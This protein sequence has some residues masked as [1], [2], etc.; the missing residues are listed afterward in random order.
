MTHQTTLQRADFFERPRTAF[1]LIEL[2]VVISIIALLIALLLPALKAARETAR[3]VSC[4]SNLRQGA[5]AVVVYATETNGYLPPGAARVG[6]LDNVYANIGDHMGMVNSSGTPLS[7]GRRLGGDAS[8]LICPSW[9]NHLNGTANQ[10]R[11]KT[12]LFAMDINRASP[13]KDNQTPATINTWSKWYADERY[14]LRRL[15]DYASSGTHMFMDANAM[16]KL[17][18]NETALW[19]PVEFDNNGIHPGFRHGSAV[20]NRRNAANVVFMDGH[21]KLVN[22]DWFLDATSADRDMFMRN[23]QPGK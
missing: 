9:E 11:A 3:Q 16:N 18:V 8:P 20:N 22:Q 17:S 7:F 21:V 2:L 23:N 15:D 12:Y 19:N 4:A 13:F 5:I 1:T 6:G 14:G 10:E